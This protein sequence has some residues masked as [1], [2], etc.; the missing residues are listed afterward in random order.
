MMTEFLL[1]VPEGWIS[2]AQE[3]TEQLLNQAAFESI[4]QYITDSV[5]WEI[6]AL[7]ENSGNT[8]PS[9]K[10]ITNARV[11]NSGTSIQ[12]WITLSE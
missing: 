11:F 3:V 1:I 12:L 9:G 4:Q 2:I 7:F 8:L 10:S 6:E 5:W